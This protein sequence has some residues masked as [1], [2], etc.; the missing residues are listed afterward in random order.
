MRKLFNILIIGAVLVSGSSCK[1]YLDVNDNP[2]NPTTQDSVGA[3]LVLPQAIATTASSLN[4]Y[5]NMGAWTAGYK[6]N[7]GGYGGWGTVWTYDLT[8]GD[9][10][11]IWTSTYESINQLDYVIRTASPTGTQRYHHAMAKIL[12]SYLYQK[13]VDQYGDVPYTE[14]GKGLNNLAP[15]YDKYSTVYQGVFSDLTAAIAI[16]NTQVDASTVAVTSGQDPL[17]GGGAG[18]ATAATHA[19]NTTRWKQF[20]NTLRLKLLIRAR[21]VPDLAAWVN[22]SKAALPTAA[23][24]YLTDDAIVQPGYSSSNANQ[25]NPRWSTYAW[26]NAGTSLTS[27]LS[28]VPT[29]WILSFYNGTKLNDPARGEMIYASWGAN[30]SQNIN[31]NTFTFSGPATNQLG[32][33]TEPVKRG[34]AGSYWYSGKP[35]SARPTGTTANAATDVAG[36]LKAATM[37]TPLLLAAEAYFLRAEAALASVNILAGNSQT[38]FE[39]GIQASY[40]YLGKNAAGNYIWPTAAA[41]LAANYRTANVNNYL[42]DWAK[43]GAPEATDRN[44]DVESR[45]LEAII[46]QK[47]IAVNMIHSDEGYNE[48]RRTGFPYIVQGSTGATE[49]FAS[50]KSAK[51][52]PDKLPTRILYPAVEFQVNTENVPKGVTTTTKIFYAKPTP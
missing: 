42:V 15:K 39:S 32:Y 10:A 4:N 36:V 49:T 41:T 47:Y 28:N 37:G 20:A 50:L 30:V 29:P 33:D 48:Y 25:F 3:A 23:T 11:A 2:N 31:G 46:T 18:N 24:D 7:A 5:D 16:M 52:T 19:T 51:T 45:R 14:V 43:T 21:L 27:G 1:K 34:V 35:R 12:R 22:T 40:N 9:Y 26:N 17:F 6:A 8:T 44:K 13:L 38:L